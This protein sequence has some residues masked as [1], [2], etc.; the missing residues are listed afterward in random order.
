MCR[1]FVKTFGMHNEFFHKKV[2]S[3]LDTFFW[4]KKVPFDGQNSMFV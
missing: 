1:V 3:S 4:C 2:F